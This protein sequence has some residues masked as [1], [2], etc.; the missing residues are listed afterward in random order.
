MDEDDQFERDLE[1]LIL[2]AKMLMEL[3]RI[4]DELDKLDKRVALSSMTDARAVLDH[5]MQKGNDV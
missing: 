2:S 4:E 5:I 3:C 1:K